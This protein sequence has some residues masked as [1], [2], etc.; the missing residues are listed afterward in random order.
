M[1][2]H[3]PNYLQVEAFENGAAEDCLKNDSHIELLTAIR[4]LLA[5]KYC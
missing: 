1:Y 3:I 4:N 2:I 5:G